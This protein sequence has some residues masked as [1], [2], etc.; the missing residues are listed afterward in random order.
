M[1]PIE[2]KKSS[3]PDEYKKSSVW[4]PIISE[5]GKRQLGIMQRCGITPPFYPERATYYQRN[6]ANNIETI[7]VYD[8]GYF[9][10]AYEWRQYWREHNAS[11]AEALTAVL[12]EKT[13]A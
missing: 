6:E 2:V 7:Y 1:K 3:E 11:P 8:G 10:K 13:R 4:I 9:W 5:D 12:L